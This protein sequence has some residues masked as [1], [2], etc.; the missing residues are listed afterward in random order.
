MGRDVQFARRRSVILH[1]LCTLDFRIATGA[2]WTTFF[3]CTTSF[4]LIRLCRLRR[5]KR[6]PT[7]MIWRLGFV[8]S[9]TLLASLYQHVDGDPVPNPGV[10]DSAVDLQVATMPR[11]RT[12]LDFRGFALSRHQGEGCHTTTGMTGADRSSS[13]VSLEPAKSGNPPPVN[14]GSECVSSQ[15]TTVQKRSFKRACKRAIQAG[16][17]QYH[18][19]TFRIQDFPKNLVQKIQD[20]MQ[21]PGPQTVRNPRRQN[22][23]SRIR[24]MNWNTGG[25]SY[26]KL[27]EMVQ[28]VRGQM[29]DIITLT[30]TRWSFEGCWQD[31]EWAFIHSPCTTKRTGGILIMISKQLVHPDSIGY[32]FL[33]PGRLAHVRLHFRQ[34]AL[35]LFAVYQHVYNRGDDTLASRATIWDALDTCLSQAPHRNLLICS[36]DFNCSLHHRSD[37]VGSAHFTWQNETHLGTRHPDMTRLTALLNHHSLLAVNTWP[38]ST[39]PTYVHGL[40]ASRIDFVLVRITQCDGQTKRV[41]MLPH[42]TFLPVNSTHHIPMICSIKRL[43]MSYH[44]HVKRQTCTYA[45]RAFCRR[46]YAQDN[47]EWQTLTQ[48]VTEAVDNQLQAASHSQPSEDPITTLHQHVAPSFH[49]LFP[50]TRNRLP[51][52]DVAHVKST[53]QLKW[54]HRQCLHALRCVQMPLLWKCYQ[55]W[56]HVSGSTRCQ[57]LQQRQLR[58]AKHC[59]FLD[60][61]A[62]V[63]RAAKLFDSQAMFQVINNYCPKRK[64]AKTRLKTIDGQIANQYQAHSLLVDYVTRTWQGPDTLPTYSDHA[65]G[66]PFSLHELQVALGQL[67]PNKSVAPPFLPAIIWKSNIHEISVFLYKLLEQW[68]TQHPPYIPATWKNAW[69]FFLPKPGKPCTEPSQLRPISLMEPLG[70]LIM[71]LL[72]SKLKIQ[73]CPKFTQD[74]HFGFLPLRAA[75]DAIARVSSHCR[76]VRAL[77]GHQRR[78]V[79]QQ[80][81][82]VPKLVF[83]GG[84]QLFLDLSRAF[85]TVSRRTLFTHLADLKLSEDLLA[86]ISAW[87]EQTEYIL[88]TN[89]LTNHI[90]VGVGLRQ[91]CKV[92]P[93]LWV[94]YMDLLISR[95]IPKIGLE[96]IRA[97]LTLYAD[98]IHVGCCFRNATEFKTALRNFGLILDTIEELQLTLSYTKSF[99]IFRHAG[100]NSRPAMK[101][102]FRTTPDGQQVLIPRSSGHATF[103]P[104]RAAGKYLGVVLSYGNF[105]MQ[106]WSHRKRAAWSAFARLKPWFHSKGLTCKNRYHLWHTCIMS[107]LTYGLLATQVTVPILLQFQAVVFQMLRRILGDH[108]YCTHHTHQEVLQLHGIPLPLTHLHRITSTAIARLSRRSDLTNAQDFTRRV[109][110]THLPEMLTLI[111]CVAPQ[112]VDTPVDANPA[113]SV[114]VQASYSCPECSFKTT[115]IANLRRHCTAVHSQSQYRTSNRNYLEMANHGKPQCNNC[116]QAFTTWRRFFI[117]VQRECCQVD[118]RPTRS[119]DHSATLSSQASMDRTDAPRT[120]LADA[121]VQQQRW[122]PHLRHLIARKDWSAAHL[123]ADMCTYLAHTCVICGLWC[124]RFQELQGHMRLHHPGHVRGMAA[125]CAQ[126]THLVQ[127][128]SP[129]NMCGQTFR[130]GHTCNVLAQIGLLY[131][132][133]DLE[134]A[135][136]DLSAYCDICHTM[137]DNL[138]QLYRHLGQVHSLKIHDWSPARMHTKTVMLADIVD[139]RL[140]RDLDCSSTSLTEDVILLTRKFPHRRWMLRP[141]GQIC[142][143][144]GIF[145]H[146]F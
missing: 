124:N 20:T 36:G 30:E 29:L 116:F 27:F 70:K 16:E 69:I 55:A 65:P 64:L 26:G 75:T 108:A 25:M 104:V 58:Q 39:G 5:R 48:V 24:L 127:C 103:L 119:G 60:L 78:T 84:I 95:L 22:S 59:R 83:C 81:D 143:H 62:E 17:T 19:R 33:V 131:I 87:H 118:P 41:N 146:S 100:T 101:G 110:W 111:D 120:S 121:H 98:D 85:D 14:P 126:L 43:H 145:P 117:H 72:A 137:Q 92:A 50:P 88:S 68:W 18:G 71:G 105:E 114:Q 94:A 9:L 54:Y 38:E 32:E 136:R 67:H 66:I 51:E 133:M 144:K 91:G 80:I 4:S 10:T 102:H 128:P 37:A 42:A 2:C 61:C 77:V 40:T 23:Q 130:R 6:R 86:L 44:T 73:M 138:Q 3:P 49:A 52:P 7:P 141:N 8:T 1:R 47:M 123:C 129:C 57:R 31:N 45:Q 132:H 139:R 115:S 122:W 125:K 90:Q 28:W 79:M 107:I 106:T 82:Q 53:I 35:D 97:N 12:L 109:D 21:K 56:I 34:R 112:Q 135:D 99:V 93:I 13:F 96:W 76:T 134:D 63:D 140:K 11:Q 89:E 142:L 15:Y 113:A 74:P 46:A